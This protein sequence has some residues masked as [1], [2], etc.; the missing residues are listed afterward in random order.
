MMFLVQDN[1]NRISSP[2]Q[3]VIWLYK[4][5]QPLYDIIKYVVNTRVEF[6]KGIPIDLEEDRYLNPNVRSMIILDDLMHIACKDTRIMDLFTEGSHHR[7]ISVIVINQ[8]LYYNKDPTQRRNCH[9]L[10]LFNSPIDKQLVMALARQMYPENAHNFMRQFQ[11][12]TNKPHGY[13]LGKS[14]THLSQSGYLDTYKGGVRS[15]A[16]RGTGEQTDIN[17]TSPQEV[18][19]KK[20]AMQTGKGLFTRHPPSFYTQR[21][22]RS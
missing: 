3:R 1:I 6:I 5:W 19:T 16:N 11:E 12:A 8:N 2:P 17:E 9:Y 10:V 22:K 18:P 14:R 20:E 15:K 4:R 7:N 13:L 21:K